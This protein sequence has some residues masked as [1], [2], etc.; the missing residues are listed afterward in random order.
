MSVI[1]LDVDGVLNT[2]HVGMDERLVSNLARII[3]ATG[4]RIV[5][6]SNWRYGGIGPGSDFEI[7][8]RHNGGEKLMSAVVDRT[9]VMETREEEILTWVEEHGVKNWVAID[10]LALD[11]PPEHFVRTFRT[12]LVSAK[13][14]EAIAKLSSPGELLSEA[15]DLLSRG[16]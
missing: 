6:S 1:F 2:D 14:D 5:V 12:G 7:S 4:A 10:D 16:S 15:F 9:G 11:L 13:A 3:E 8:M